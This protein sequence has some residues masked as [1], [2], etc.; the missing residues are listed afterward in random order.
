MAFNDIYRVRIHCRI[1]GGE[2]INVWHFMVNAPAGDSALAL[3]TEIRDSLGTEMRARASNEMSFEYVEA[4]KLVPYGEGPATASWPAATLGTVLSTC[5][6]G[7][8]AEVVTV[9]TSQI[10]RAHRGRIFFGGLAVNRIGSGLTLT[11]QQT[12]TQALVTKISTRYVVEPAA[13]G[14]R[15]GVWSRKLAGPN[16]PFSTDAFTLCTS[17]TVRTILRNQ[18]RR[19]IG[20]GR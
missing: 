15:F 4:V 5:P 8:L 10:G 12:A 11:A 2:N 7:S 19:Q 3:A 1:H 20:V 13:T 16:P 14:Y 18:R 17:M 9:Y 6:S